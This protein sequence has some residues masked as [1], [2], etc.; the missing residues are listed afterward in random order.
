M[1]WTVRDI[2]TVQISTSK[3]KSTYTFQVDEEKNMLKFFA[4]CYAGYDVEIWIYDKTG[5]PVQF[6]VSDLNRFNELRTRI[7]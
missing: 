2:D 5:T 1:N 3:I 7:V 6:V 4:C